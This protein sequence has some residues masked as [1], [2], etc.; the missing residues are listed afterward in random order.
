MSADAETSTRSLGASHCSSR[1]PALNED[2][3]FTQR[4]PSLKIPVHSCSE[5]WWE[6]TLQPRKFTSSFQGF[7]PFAL[8]SKYRP[9]SSAI[10]AV[11]FCASQSFGPRLPPRMCTVALWSTPKATSGRKK[12]LMRSV[13]PLGGSILRT[14]MCLPSGST[15]GPEGRSAA[16]YVMPSILDPSSRLMGTG[17]LL[18]V[19]SKRSPVTRKRQRPRRGSN[20]QTRAEG[21]GREGN[22]GGPGRATARFGRRMTA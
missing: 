5:R 13:R 19:G 1:R 7:P 20:R 17:P 8:R 2:S 16:L 21:P 9:Q 15:L 4:E 3:T 18:S 10:S 11:C 14:C 22:M 6:T 12:N